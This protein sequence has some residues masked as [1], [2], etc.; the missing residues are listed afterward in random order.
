VPRYTTI[1]KAKTPLCLDSELSLREVRLA[2]LRLLQSSRSVLGGQATADGAGL[3]GPEVKGKV[4]LVLVEQAELSAL[5]GVDDGQDAGNRL[6]DV[7]D[8]GELGARRDDLL[9][10]E[11][12]QLGLELTELLGE[13]VLVLRP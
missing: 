13:L 6:A 10:A 4:L 3:L 2:L 7:V 8:L 1:P 5:L 11:L 9:N 12:A